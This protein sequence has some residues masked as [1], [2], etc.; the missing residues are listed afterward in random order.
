M[1]KFV[2]YC[3]RSSFFIYLWVFLTLIGLMFLSSS[4][5]ADLVDGDYTY[6][7]SGGNATVTGYTGPNGPISIP[8]TLGGFPTVAIKDYAFGDSG[9][10]DKPALTGLII[11]SS[12]KTI[13][14]GAF[15]RCVNVT[16]VTIPEGVETIGIKA[17]ARMYALQSVYIPVS[18]T[19]IGDY[20]FYGGTSN[21]GI[22]VHADNPNYSSQEGVLYNKGITKLIQ[23]PCGKAGALIIPATVTSIGIAA[24]ELSAG[25]I[26]SITF[27]GNVET[28]AEAAFEGLTSLTSIAF[29]SSLTSIGPWA[30]YGCTSLTGVYFYGNAPSMGSAVFDSCAGGFTVYYL[31]GATG[32]TNPWYG[33]PTAVFTPPSTTTTTTVAPTTTTTPVAPTTTTSAN[34]TTTTSIQPTTSSSSSSSTTTIPT[35]NI[36]ALVRE[37]Y[38]DILDREP[39]QGG[40]DYWV[41]EIER[42]MSL[43]VYVGEGFQAEARFFFNTAEYTNKN[44]T[45]AQF[46][47]DLYQAFLQRNPDPGGLNYHV[48]R[49]SCLT[50]DMLITDFAYTPEFQQYMTN[51]FGPDTTRPENN[52]VNDFFRGLLNRFP[53][54]GG[55]NYWRQQM[56]VAQC[57]GA[58]AVQQLSYTI[59]LDFMQ[60]PEYAARNRNNT[61]YVEDLYNGILRRAGDCDGFTFW[62]NELNSGASRAAALESFTESPEFQTRVQAV[63]DAGCLP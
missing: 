16:S 42:I 8:L 62:I 9:T 20:G 7:E 11:P 51:L 45:N 17:F 27:T 38:L 44:K 24:C 60:S 4:A 25:N 29:P 22:T 34:S 14:E 21:T 55:F 15:R 50:R 35:E 26:T 41:S 59:A 46:V 32:F 30:F 40:W 43:G 13:G 48:G 5:F 28:I 58:A 52:L 19:S 2:G 3:Y 63:I 37:Y 61:Q 18:V 1:K 23:Y 54:N 56:R 57:T 36:R 6:T 53:D 33:Y 49:L 10:T 12:V 47:T 31:D 39:D